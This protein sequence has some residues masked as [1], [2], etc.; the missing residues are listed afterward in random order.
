[1]VRGCVCFA[2]PEHGSGKCG[3]CW[4][5]PDRTAKPSVRLYSAEAIEGHESRDLAHRAVLDSVKTQWGC[6][7]GGDPMRSWRGSHGN[8]VAS[9]CRY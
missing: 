6:S 1:M 2:M 4:I 7:L 8:I 9:V 3:E 5:A